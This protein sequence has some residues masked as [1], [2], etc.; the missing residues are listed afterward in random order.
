MTK[1]HIYSLELYVQLTAFFSFQAR[2]AE[3]RCESHLRRRFRWAIDKNTA[4]PTSL[5]IFVVPYGG[6]MFLP[7]L[8]EKPNSLR[9]KWKSPYFCQL[10]FPCRQCRRQNPS[11][12]QACRPATTLIEPLCQCVCEVLSLSTQWNLHVVFATSQVQSLFVI[13]VFCRF[14]N[15]AIGPLEPF[16]KSSTKNSLGKETHSK[17]FWFCPFDLGSFMVFLWKP[18]HLEGTSQAQKCRFLQKI[19]YSIRKC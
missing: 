5:V 16:Q 6:L 8:V 18:G 1:E 19:I 7:K 2:A 3:S 12:P 10:P 17:D 15:S 9:K 13:F 4:V 14:K 11:D